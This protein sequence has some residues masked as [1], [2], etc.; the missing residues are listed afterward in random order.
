MNENTAIRRGARF[1][2]GVAIVSFTVAV[3]A[4]GCDDQDSRK[5]EFRGLLGADSKK[6]RTEDGKTYIWA[7]GDRTGPGAE[8]YDFTGSPIPTAELQYGIGKDRI[9]AIDDPLFVKPDD[10]RLAK[11]STSPYR[12]AEK[13]ENND[14]IMVIGYVVNGEARAYPT[15]LLD[16]HELVNDRV[17]G[18][19]VTVGW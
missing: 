17:G 8:W 2:M 18:K 11:I 13:R 4:H 5:S 7:G 14:D 10:P 16:H 6:V 9:R 3:I 12:P 19:P 1:I 15:A